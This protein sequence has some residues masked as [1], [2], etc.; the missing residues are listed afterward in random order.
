[1]TPLKFLPLSLSFSCLIRK[2]EKKKMMEWVKCG[3]G[4]H[5]KRVFLPPIHRDSI[6]HSIK[7]LL[8]M[9][10]TSP[11]APHLHPHQTKR[12]ETKKM[13]YWGAFCNSSLAKRNFYS[14]LSS[15][16]I[17]YPV[18]SSFPNPTPSSPTTILLFLSL[19][20]IF[21]ES[22]FG[23]GEVGGD[24]DLGKVVQKMTSLL[25]ESNDMVVLEPSARA[26]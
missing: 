7:G 6:L 1:M 4:H 17:P 8:T 3:F 23:R 11:K 15:S 9:S 20:M 12:K 13:V 10:P 24:K 2:C 5:L 19:D 25:C 18:P 16:H 26:S 14:Q 21:V 22:S